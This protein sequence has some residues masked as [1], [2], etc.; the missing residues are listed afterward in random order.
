MK[1]FDDPVDPIH[2][3]VEEAFAIT[4]TGNPTT[5]Y[6]WHAQVDARYLDLTAQEFEPAS[7][8]VGAGGQEVFH[9]RARR[10]TETEI[11][12]EYRRPWGTEAHDTK[13]FQVVIE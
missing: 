9:F 5:G 3:A 1:Q 8:A 4:L 6:T 12:F 10:A 2:V 11:A 13:R 7:E